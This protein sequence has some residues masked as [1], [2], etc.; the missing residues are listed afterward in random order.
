MWYIYKFLPFAGCPIS[1]CFVLVLIPFVS[2]LSL[3]V[4]N[5]QAKTFL[6]QCVWRVFV[7]LQSCEG[8]PENLLC[9]YVKIT[10]LQN[11]LFRFPHSIF[12]SHSTALYDKKFSWMFDSAFFSVVVHRNSLTKVIP[13]SILSLQIWRTF[14]Y[15][16]LSRH[17]P[18]HF[19]FYLVGTYMAIIVS[20]Q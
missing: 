18:G 19:C 16:L 10:G 13:A 14:L 1:V 6:Q 5:K 3:P 11:A 15:V 7:V 20:K 2:T 12:L 8:Y 9:L 17:L 4:A